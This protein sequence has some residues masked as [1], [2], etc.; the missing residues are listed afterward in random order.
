[1]QNRQWYLRRAALQLFFVIAG[2]GVATADGMTGGSVLFDTPMVAQQDINSVTFGFDVRDARRQLTFDL[3]ASA[4]LRLGVGFSTY[5]GGDTA[6]T[7]NDLNLSFT[8]LLETANLPSLSVG[9]FGIGAEGRGAGEYLATSKAFG[10]LRATAGL[11][12]GRFAGLNQSRGDDAGA[13]RTD[14]LFQGTREGFGSLVWQT[15]VDGLEAGLEYGAVAGGDGD[16]G[17]RT[18]LSYTTKRNLSFAGFVNE[19]GD[20]GLQLRLI[21]NPYRPNTLPDGYSAPP[22]LVDRPIGPPVPDAALLARLQE[23]FDDNPVSLRR[24]AVDGDTIY[25]TVRGAGDRNFARVAGRVSR[26]LSVTAPDQYT[27]FAITQTAGGFE[28]DTIMIDRASLA[29]AVNR[30]DGAR[31]VFDAAQIVPTPRTR[32]PAI[33]EQGHN[34]WT[35]FSIKPRFSFD[36]Q[37][38]DELTFVGDLSATALYAPTASTQLRGQLGYR[39]LNKWDQADAPDTPQVRSDFTAYDPDT[40]ALLAA[41]ATYRTKLTDTVYGRVSGGLFERMYGGVSLEAVWRDPARNFALGLEGT[42]VQKRAYDA[43]LGF[44]DLTASTLISSVYANLGSQGDFVVLDAGRYLAGDFGANL[45]VGRDFNNG[46]RVAVFTKWSEDVDEPLA[47]GVAINIPLDWAVP[48]EGND[49]LGVRIGGR[50]GNEASAVGGT[51]RL[52]NVLRGSDP[53]RLEDEWG[54]FW[55]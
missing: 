25:V 47:F 24:L 35:D 55:D 49:Q 50:S 16:V 19:D 4:R 38:S 13:V 31:Q 14:H 15:P 42:H 2:S 52:Y 33:F 22:L 43:P 32:A 48:L 54:A 17:W 26:I 41:T 37:S 5:L 27:R 8:P 53:Q 9:V 29:P 34:S 23:R 36:W 6:I 40:V 46:W 39:F 45:T 1:V 30:P 28:L 44:E 20:A 7:G 18:G 51:G 10:P 3:Q 12:W 11:G 21:A